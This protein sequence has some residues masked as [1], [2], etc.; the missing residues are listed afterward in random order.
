MTEFAR[1]DYKGLPE[2]G[3]LLPVIGTREFLGMPMV[4]LDSAGIRLM[5]PV[6]N[7]RI[8]SASG[9]GREAA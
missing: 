3:R 5:V 7:A 1:V 9:A 8:V 6:G 4:V 2:H